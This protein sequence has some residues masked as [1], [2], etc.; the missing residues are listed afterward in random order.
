MT[1]PLGFWQRL[2]DLSHT[3]KLIDEEDKEFIEAQNNNDDQEAIDD[4]A[5]A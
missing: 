3:T 5:A 1:A 2:Q 4:A